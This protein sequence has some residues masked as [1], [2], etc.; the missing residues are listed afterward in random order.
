VRA[1]L[2]RRYVPLTSPR[3]FQEIQGKVAEKP[4]LANRIARSDISDFF[5][6]LTRVGE[7][8]DDADTRFPAITRDPKDDYLLA[9]AVIYRADYLVTGDR[10][11]LVIGEFEGIRI[12]TPAEFEALLEA[13]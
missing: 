2:L 6:R 5:N 11:L 1:A 4:Y 7:S 13:G 12:V 10:D 3:L 9:N 8:H